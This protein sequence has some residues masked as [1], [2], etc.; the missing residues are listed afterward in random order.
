MDV[1]GRG[2]TNFDGKDT[3]HC[4]TVFGYAVLFGHGLMTPRSHCV[5]EITE[6]VNDPD[7]MHN[8]VKISRH[9]SRQSVARVQNHGI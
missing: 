3:C 8:S 2:S 9:F 7:S 4:I 5:G 6:A 1:I